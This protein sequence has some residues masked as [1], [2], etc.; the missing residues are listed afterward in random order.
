M[1]QFQGVCA[2][3]GGRKAV[4]E[5]SFTI[6]AGKVTALTGPNGCGKTTLLKT[7]CGLIKPISGQVL[8]D[9]RPVGGYRRR[10]LARRLAMLPQ[11]REVPAVTVERL[12]A[13]G[14]YPHL[15]LGR[16]LS[17]RDWERVEAALEEAGA[18]ELRYRE[19]GKLS[20]GERQRAYIAMALAQDSG[21]L[22]LDEPTTYLDVRHQLETL[23]LTRRLAAEGRGV[24][25]VL[26]DLCLAL[27]A[28]D[29]VAVL[30]SGRLLALGDPEEIFESRILEEVMGVRLD[31]SAG[32]RGWRYFCELPEEA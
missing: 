5:V 31:R 22:L 18:K 6:P 19:L 11:T 9:G 30:G 4:R 7:A 10:E 13:Y 21:C 14:R 12:A 28:A 29:E 3:Y 16:A 23:A 8:L 24:A 17:A 1:I 20:G 26:H 15:G 27:A 2:G 32:P 25:V